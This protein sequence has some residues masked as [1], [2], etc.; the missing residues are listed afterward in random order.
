MRMRL[1]INS[2][3]QYKLTGWLLYARHTSRGSK[4]HMDNTVST[5]REYMDSTVLNPPQTVNN[6]KRYTGSNIAISW[7]QCLVCRKE[8]CRILDTEYTMLMF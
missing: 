1:F 5:L 3:T 4:V 6:L 8:T 7:K 2:L